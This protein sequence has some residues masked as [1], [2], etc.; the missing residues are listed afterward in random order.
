MAVLFKWLVILLVTLALIVFAVVNRSVVTISLFPLPYEMALPLY[1]FVLIFF[2]CGFCIAWL[3]VSARR[4][5][6]AMT[7]RRYKR[8]IDALE[9]ELRGL[10]L[11][12]AS[13]PSS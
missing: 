9:N 8:R 5:G 4:A 3:L 11:Q 6:D 1:L 12:R 13:L 10:R 7:A 2:L